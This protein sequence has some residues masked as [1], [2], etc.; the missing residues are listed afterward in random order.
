MAFA[1]LV[2]AVLLALG[3][4]H[5]VALGA[6]SMLYVALFTP[7]DVVAI[8]QSM[9]FF[10]SSYTV[11]AIPFFIYA[12]FL[13]E[14]TGLMRQL[15]NFAEALL[16]WLPGGIGVATIL[17]CMI[18]AAISGSA[19]AIAATLGLI[20][21]PA[22]VE[23]GYPRSMAAG[24]IAIG[25]GIGLLIPPSLSL[26][27]FGIATE[28]SIPDLFL[29]GVVPGALFGVA[30]MV[31][32][33][34]WAI[35]KRLP[36]SGRFSLA[37]LWRAFWA[38]LP[39]LGMPA[40]VLGGI[41]GGV[42]TPT[43]AGAV[44]CAYAIAYG[45]LAERR[46]FLDQLLPTTKDA[47]NLTTM[48]FALLASLGLFQF[49]AANLYWPQTIAEYLVSLKLTPFTFLL[50]YMIVLIILGTFL[51]GVAM[52]LLTVPV[53]FPAALQ[54]GVDPVQLGV[55]ISINVEL[56]AISPPV[57]L[58]L[59]AISGATGIPQPEI[60][61]GST[62]YFIVACL[63]MLLVMIFPQLSTWLPSVL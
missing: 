42:F 52:I 43:E 3:V 21:I 41:Y 54:I 50:G 27:L 29:G 40:V 19:T 18:F 28:T 49:V 7:M 32:T 44:A 17:T 59:Y 20:A 1:A 46:K 38:A 35:T 9:F 57:G 2:L 8:G 4:P 56:A 13:M 55:L 23:R 60:L 24:M 22:M 12:G 48:I 58:N 5:A 47:L 15:F 63:V 51:E 36:T 34:V 33:V 53:I 61:R 31:V 10:L 25:A 11:M 37:R 30:M 39:G 62:P 6:A 45:A 16:G 14:K 26:I